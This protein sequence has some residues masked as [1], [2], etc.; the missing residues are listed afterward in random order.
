MR[1]LVLEQ[2]I[3]KNLNVSKTEE[4]I[5][6]L[7]SKNSSEKSSGKGVSNPTY[8]LKDV[9]LFLNTVTRGMSMMK[10][11]GI[12]AECGKNETDTDITLIIKIPKSSEI[13]H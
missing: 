8:I 13:A 10:Q 2:I 5:D 11:S 3:H 7:L 4:L 12:K 9:R 6:E 1:I